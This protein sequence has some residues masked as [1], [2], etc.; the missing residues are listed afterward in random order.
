MTEAN[1]YIPIDLDWLD[2][3]NADGQLVLGKPS[4]VLVVRASVEHPEGI[5]SR[6]AAQ[7]YA[8]EL[9]RLARVGQQLEDATRE[10]A[11]VGAGVR[12]TGVAVA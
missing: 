12:V 9:I 8:R 1:A 6:E 11:L 10:A 3:F 4:G 7:D 2:E 5:R